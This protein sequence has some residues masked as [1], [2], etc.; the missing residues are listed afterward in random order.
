MS[1]LIFI[2]GLLILTGGIIGHAKAGSHASLVMGTVFGLLLLVSGFGILLK[3]YL[4]PA[5]YLA[6]ILTFILDAFFTYRYLNSMKFMP[7]GLLAL[8][9]L[10]VMLALVNYIR[11]FKSSN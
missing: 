5:T 6:L 8:V 11:R 10:G 9:S 2:Y 3:K 4:K 1:Y 7:S